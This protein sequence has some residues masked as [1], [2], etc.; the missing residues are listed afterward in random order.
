MLVWTAWNRTVYLYKM[1]LILNNQQSLKCHKIQRTKQTNETNQLLL[2]NKF[3]PKCI[4][5]DTIEQQFIY[6]KNNDS[7]NIN[8]ERNTW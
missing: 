4:I 6:I 8:L 7:I 3:D 1:D 2:K 5:F